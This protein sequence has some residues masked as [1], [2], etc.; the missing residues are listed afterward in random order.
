[1][2]DTEMKKKRREDLMQDVE[3]GELYEKLTMWGIKELEEFEDDF[4]SEICLVHPKRALIW[5]PIGP[6]KDKAEKLVNS[7]LETGDAIAV[8]TIGKGWAAPINENEDK[9]KLPLKY[10][11]NSYEFFSTRLESKEI[12][13]IKMWKIK[14]DEKGRMIFPLGEPEVLLEDFKSR[15]MGTYFRVTQKGNKKEESK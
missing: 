2:R 1:M 13:K 4:S 8:I 15:S 11:P 12:K 10:Y 14:R 5:I 3:I 7:L 9:P 6:D